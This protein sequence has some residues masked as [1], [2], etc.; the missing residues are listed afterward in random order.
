MAAR[1]KAKWIKHPGALGGPGYTKRPQSDRRA[2]LKRSIKRRGYTKTI[3]SVQV[4]MRPR[5]IRPLTRAV[6]ASDVYWL[7]KQHAKALARAR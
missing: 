3:Q 2:I 1:K 6:L 7:H 4:L 5:N